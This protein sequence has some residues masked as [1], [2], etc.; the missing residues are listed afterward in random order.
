MDPIILIID[1]GRA[2][3]DSVPADISGTMPLTATWF[4]THFQSREQF[5]GV[6]SALACQTG[7]IYRYAWLF[8]FQKQSPR[9]ECYPRREKPTKF[10][11]WASPPLAQGS[12]LACFCNFSLIIHSCLTNG[13]TALFLWCIRISLWLSLSLKI[14]QQ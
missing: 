2:G 14:K 4:S 12:A 6:C 1:M 3:R 9:R 13:P 10:Q 11:I 8:L 5:F 7:D